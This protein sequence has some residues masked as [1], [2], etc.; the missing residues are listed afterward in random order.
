VAWLITV[1]ALGIAGLSGYLFF[2]AR[3]RAQF[4]E[5]TVVEMKNAA[6]K[7]D[8]EG[9]VRF[10]HDPGGPPV[11]K[12]HCRRCGKMTAEFLCLPMGMEYGPETP[13]L[14]TEGY[15]GPQ[16]TPSMPDSS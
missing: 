14:D 13:P 16:W 2:R 4:H 5:R 11:V 7:C 15:D 1:I 9:V 10:T 12:V 3:T 6:H 8:R